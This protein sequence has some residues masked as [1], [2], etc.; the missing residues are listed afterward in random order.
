[1]KQAFIVTDLSFGDAGKGTTVDY[2]VRQASS[3][4]VIRY[5][6]GPQAAHNVVTPDGRHHTFAQF[7]SGTFV[8][9]VVSHL[10]R[11]M[12]INPL[13]M[14][15]EAH[16]LEQVG[17]TDA[18]ERT[19][20][21]RQARLIT[22]W[23]QLANHFRERARGEGRH[24]SC[25]QGI[26]ETMSD[27]V[28]HPGLVLRAEDIEWPGRLQRKLTALRDYKISQLIAEFGDT[29]LLDSEWQNLQDP[30]LVQQL[31]DAYIV[32]REQVR[33]VDEGYLGQLAKRYETLV[34]EGSQGV[35]LDEWRGFHPY[36]TWSTTTPLNARRQLDDVHYDGNVQTLGVL[37]A[38][39]TRHGAGPFVTEVPALKQPLREDHNDTGEWQGEFRYGYFD[40]VAH[41]YAM[42][43]AETVDRL[44]VTGL[45]RMQHLGDWCYCESYDVP[46]ESDRTKYFEFDPS[47]MAR[48]I[49][50]GA[51][52]DLD[53]QARLTELLFDSHP[54]YCSLSAM[55]GERELLEVIEAALGAPVA[56]T[57]HGPTE[58]DKHALVLA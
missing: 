13:N 56:L 14:F 35:L 57:S 9:G 21:D 48:R 3:A 10:S 46:N 58:A 45:D 47:G 11:D 51:W 39:T 15:S 18:W 26:G 8:P 1:M 4:A 50:L 29:L 34:F 49:R 44:V 6:G 52:Q 20:V 38:Y 36:T 24:G 43:A 2:L 37:R 31:V 27:W 53:Y 22:P 23:Q 41:R 25:G 28:D 40:L 5:N 19:T 32:W 55:N 16:H 42:D 12:L 7:G 54:N 30:T 33:F 17:V